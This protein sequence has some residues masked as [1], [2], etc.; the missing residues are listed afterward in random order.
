MAPFSMIAGGARPK[1]GQRIAGRREATTGGDEQRDPAALELGDRVEHP[2][3]QVVVGVPERAV[4]VGDD[5]V[6]GGHRRSL[7]GSR[8]RRQGGCAQKTPASMPA[9][10]VAACSRTWARWASV[11]GPATTIGRQ[12]LL[13]AQPGEDAGHVAHRAG[14]VVAALAH[15]QVGQAR[16]AVGHLLEPRVDALEEVLH[17]ARH[18]PEVLR[19]DQ[20]RARRG[21]H[22]VGARLGR[23]Q[24]SAPAAGRRRR[25]PRPAP[26]PAARGSTAAPGATRPASH[27]FCGR[28]R[29]PCERQRPQIVGQPGIWLRNMAMSK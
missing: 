23:R 2:V 5:E 6:D 10:R 7:R 19:R 17:Q 20:H 3:G 14:A 8:G 29:P 26:R 22:V 21:L 13:P 24:A 27:R 16:T 28:I 15:E 25:P 12:R 18:H 4:E 1:R 9:A 11:S